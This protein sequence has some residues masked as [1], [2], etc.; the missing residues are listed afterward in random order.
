MYKLNLGTAL[1]VALCS[2]ERRCQV[3]TLSRGFG[4][5]YGTHPTFLA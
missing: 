4:G 2:P 3:E 1:P 5:P